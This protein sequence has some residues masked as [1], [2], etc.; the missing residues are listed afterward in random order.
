LR[1]EKPGDAVGALGGKIGTWVEQPEITG[2]CHLNHAVLHALHGP[3]E[4]FL[5]RPRPAEIAALEFR[6]KGGHVDGRRHRARLN[7]RQGAT[8]FT[9]QPFIDAI[10]L[11][12]RGE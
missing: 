6:S 11:R 1:I 3:A 2:V 9:A 10:A 4:Q 7:S 12:N 8:Q 5:E